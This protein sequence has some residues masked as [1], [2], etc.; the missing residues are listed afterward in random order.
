MG[1]ER[2]S[3]GGGRRWRELCRGALILRAEAR[4]PECGCGPALH[5]ELHRRER[6]HGACRG[7]RPGPAF[8]AK[9][10]GLPQLC[11]CRKAPDARTRRFCGVPGLHEAGL[12]AL[13]AVRYAGALAL[14]DA[15]RAQPQSGGAVRARGAR[16]QAVRE[17]PC[18]KRHAARFCEAEA[19]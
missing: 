2:E 6:W 4:G 10:T 8:V 11:D 9:R 3:G 13:R 12:R 16:T 15:R 1:F 7:R 14:D 5:D 18:E 17:K 19:L